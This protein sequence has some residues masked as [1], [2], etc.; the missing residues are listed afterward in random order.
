[1]AVGSFELPALPEVPGFRFA[2]GVAGIKASGTPDMMLA[3]MD[4][5]AAVAGVFTQNQAAAAP[6]R[7]CRQRLSRGLARGLV[8]NS[9]NANACTPSGLEDAR[10]VCQGLARLMEI[11]QELIFPASTGVIGVTLPVGKILD[12]LPGLLQ[13]AASEGLSAAA[14]AIMTTDTFPKGNFRR[15]TVDGVPV[16]VAGIAKGAGMIHPNM[17]TLLVYLFTDAAIAAPALQTL[18]DRAVNRSFNRITVDGDTSTNDTLMIFASGSA[19]H[20]PI[21]S[22]EDPRAATLDAALTELCL[23]LAQWVVRDGEGATKLISITVQ[24]ARTAGEALQIAKAVAHSPLVKTAC[25]GRDPNWGRI[26]A[27]VG[28]AGVPL[29]LDRVVITLGGVTIVEG[30]CR[31]AGYT[32]AAGDEAMNREEIPIVI[33]LGLG[34]AEETV[35]TCD[36]SHGYISINADYRT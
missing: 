29:E 28:Y 23:E 19:A 13:S 11:P 9:G 16:V 30:G 32:E 14:R 22:A 5:P 36:Y 24:R 33:D 35:W 4:G 27:A 7:L 34:D 2:S 6:V 18:L 25:F 10:A 8:V 3:V 21:V 17:A 20:A 15:L 31:A 12:A 26:L 1:M